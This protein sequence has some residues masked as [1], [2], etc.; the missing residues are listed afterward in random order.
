MLG[1]H[2]RPSDE[3]ARFQKFCN[4]VTWGL[5]TLLYPAM[6]TH[7][8]SPVPG[9]VPLGSL[10]TVPPAF[11]TGTVLFTLQ[12]SVWEAPPWWNQ[13]L[14]TFSRR[15]RNSWPT[16]CHGV[17]YENLGLQ[18]CHVTVVL[19]L[20]T[21]GKYS[22]LLDRWIRCVNT[23]MKKWRANS[24]CKEGQLGSKKTCKKWIS[25]NT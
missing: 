5:S 22:S 8:H 4:S 3:D 25:S 10:P 1:Q 18:V 12:E 14:H 11:P 19:H 15:P 6:W 21:Y 9:W 2:S 7:F 16:V 17:H 20:G 13:L 23:Q 24:W